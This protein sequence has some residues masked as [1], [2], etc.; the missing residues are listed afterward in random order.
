MDCH[1]DKQGGQERENVGLDKC[2]ENSSR[3]TAVAPSTLAGH[4]APTHMIELPAVAAIN[5]INTASTTWPPI[6]FAKQTHGQHEVLDHEARCTSIP[7]IMGPK[8]RPAAWANP[9]GALG[10]SKSRSGRASSCPRRPRRQTSQC[11]RGG[12]GKRSRRGAH[13]GQHAHQIAAEDEE[14]HRP[15]SGHEPIDIVRTDRRPCYVIAEIKQKHFKHVPEPAARRA[16]RLE[17]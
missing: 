5:A 12:Y 7:K 3:L 16:R 10:L 2:H 9:C 11:Q 14:K 13:P 4:H 1:A 17:S 8:S 6:M 15:N